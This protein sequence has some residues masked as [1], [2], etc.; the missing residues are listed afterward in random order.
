MWTIQDDGRQAPVLSGS[1]SNGAFAGVLRPAAF[2][3]R[4]NLFR[5]V[6]VGGGQTQQVEIRYVGSAGRGMVRARVGTNDIAFYQ[7]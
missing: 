6:A 1:V 4:S 7:K 5:T 2:D 3:Y